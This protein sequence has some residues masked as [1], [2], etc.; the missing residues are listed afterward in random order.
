MT[1]SIKERKIFGNFV[2]L[3]YY[4]LFLLDANKKQSTTTISHHV[5]AH[6]SVAI[7]FIIL[8]QYITNTRLPIPK[9]APIFLSRQFL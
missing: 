5:N 9:A 1:I 3:C 7:I 8:K 4:Q 6:R 2:D